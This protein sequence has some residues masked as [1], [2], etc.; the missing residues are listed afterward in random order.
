MESAR[1]ATVAA[2]LPEQATPPGTAGRILVAGLELFAEKGFSGTSIRDIG[3]RL[4][5]NSATLYSHY[6]SKEHV[7][8][9][10]V[11]LGHQ[12]LHTRLQRALV[13]SRGG[14]AEQL[15]AL[16]RAHV[17]AHAEYPLLALVANA[18]LHAL[19]SEAAAP[20]LALRE[21]SW[22]LLLAVLDE[23]VRCGEFTV[24]DPLL[25]AAAIVSMGR[26]VAHWYGPRQPYTPTQIADTFSGYALAVAG[27]AHYERE[28]T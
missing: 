15:V 3:A 4:G 14:P 1:S 9:A 8:A 21:Q 16:V 11:L 18:E 6:R 12:E 19:G 5:I 7:L 17:L 23:G 25:A 26:Q 10:L 27:A 13:A 24:T 28:S 22:Q 20:A 2:E